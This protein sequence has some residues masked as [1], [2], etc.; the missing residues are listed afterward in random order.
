M[1]LFLLATWATILAYLCC[2]AGLKL[3]GGCD[4]GYDY[5]WAEYDAII[6]FKSPEL[7]DRGFNPRRFLD[8]DR[9]A[10]MSVFDGAACDNGGGGKM[11]VLAETC[12]LVTVPPVDLQGD[13]PCDFNNDI[14]FATLMVTTPDRR[15]RVVHFAPSCKPWS[16]AQ[17]FNAH[18]ATASSKTIK[19]QELQRQAMAKMAVLLKAIHSYSGEI[20][21]ENP[22]HSTYWNQQFVRE[23]ENDIPSGRECG[24]ASRW[25]SVGWAAHTRSACAH[26]TPRRRTHA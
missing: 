1:N 22:S 14:V 23:F 24:A 2:T 9:A 26:G 4:P 11:N 6:D 25:T 12:G 8:G 19:A 15:P 16:Q 13:H 10:F 17:R 21:I 7:P 3:Y 20:M 18:N 5:S